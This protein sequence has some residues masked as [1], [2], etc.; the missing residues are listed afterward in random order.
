MGG[1]AWRASDLNG[2]PLVPD[3][4]LTLELQGGDRVSGSSGCNSYSGS[5]RLMNKAGID[6]TAL[7]STR[8][9]CAPELMEQERRF[10]SILESVEGYT[11]YSDGGLS[12]ISPD[13][14]AIRFRR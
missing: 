13:G 6:F 9:A 1:I 12:L 11:F 3:S 7:V 10:L 14:R 4:L 2:V 8:K 5:Y